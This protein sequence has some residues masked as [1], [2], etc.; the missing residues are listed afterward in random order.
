MPE[1]FAHGFLVTSE[2]A[3]FVY[4]CTAT[5]NAEADAGILYNDPEI[6]I[7]WPESS[8]ALSG[9]DAAAP[10]LAEMPEER[11]PKY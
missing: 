4:K 8:P 3:L 1:G 6:G 2:T 5:Y 9:K 7:E 11:L 10:R